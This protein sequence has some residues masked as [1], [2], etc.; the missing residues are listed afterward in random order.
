MLLKK[1]TLLIKSIFSGKSCWRVILKHFALVI[2]LCRATAPWHY[3]SQESSHNSSSQ[4]SLLTARAQT[5]GS[6]DASGSPAAYVA[7][8][9]GV[10]MA[11]TQNLPHLNHKDSCPTAL[12]VA[13]GTWHHSLVA[14]QCFRVEETGKPQK[15]ATA[16]AEA[17][18]F[19]RAIKTTGNN[20]LKNKKQNIDVARSLSLL[21][22]WA[23]ISIA[24]FLLFSLD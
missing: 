23:S 15:N 7:Y 20:R 6:P 22:S 17:I 18:I 4:P 3:W 12:S 24:S 5:T 2:L 10:C 11:H 14:W 9:H 8:C 1:I 16:T 13:P 19:T 21:S